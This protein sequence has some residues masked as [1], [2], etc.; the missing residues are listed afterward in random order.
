MNNAYKPT[1][2]FI[3]TTCSLRGRAKRPRPRRQVKKDRRHSLSYVENVFGRQRRHR[4]LQPAAVEWVV[5]IH[6]TNKFVRNFQQIMQNEPKFPHFSPK[7]NDSRKKRTQTNPNKLDSSL[8]APTLRIHRILWGQT[9]TNP[10][11]TKLQMV[12]CNL[13]IMLLIDILNPQNFIP[14]HVKIGKGVIS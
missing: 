3:R 9:Q 11:Y 4:A 1:L 6:S 2:E 8:F 10:I 5:R 14:K 12:S 13:T 7:N